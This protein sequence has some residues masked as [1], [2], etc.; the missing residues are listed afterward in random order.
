MGSN[1]TNI[2]STLSI[3]IPLP[4]Q[5]ISGKIL[6]DDIKTIGGLRIGLYADQLISEDYT[7]EKLYFQ[8][9]FYKSGYVLGKTRHL[10]L[11][12]TKV[13]NETVPMKGGTSNFRGI[14]IPTF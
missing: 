14:F 10:S 2:S 5:H 11:I 9:S 8:K 4:H 7:S 1:C 12:L 3:S 6:L 13:I